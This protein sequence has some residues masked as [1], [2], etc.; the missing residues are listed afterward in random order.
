MPLYAGVWYAQWLAAD[1]CCGADAYRGLVVLPAV[2][3]QL[4]E[5]AA[6]APVTWEH[7]AMQPISESLPGNEREAATKHGRAA[8]VVKAAWV[9]RATGHAHVVFEIYDTMPM[10]CALVD[11]KMLRCLSATHIVGQTTMVELSL[12]NTP[13][14]PGCNIF[15]R[16][17]S[18]ADYIR[19]HPPL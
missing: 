13:A 19:L 9:A 12:T 10:I 18:I 2:L 3:D 4:C 14:R 5:S 7:S 6:G 16:V 8:G 1:A 15:G 11:S 17:S